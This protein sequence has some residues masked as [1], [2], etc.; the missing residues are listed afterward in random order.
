MHWGKFV[1]HKKDEKKGFES[2]N[3]V[4]GEEKAFNPSEAT[5]AV[6]QHCVL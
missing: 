6:F 1:L 4:G 5:N 3:T 2:I